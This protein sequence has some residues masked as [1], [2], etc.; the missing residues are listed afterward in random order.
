MDNPD[1][2]PED[3][4]LLEGAAAEPDEA[5]ASERGGEAAKPGDA[6]FSPDVVAAS[7]RPLEAGSILSLAE[8]REVAISKAAA[9]LR[10]GGLVVVPTDTVYGVAANAFD[11]N[12][13]AK[14]FAAKNRPRS[15][16]LPV[17]VSRPRQAW[18]L[19]SFVPPVAAELAAEFWPGALTLV[20]P[21]TEL[22]WDLGDATGTIALRMPANPD[23][24]ELLERVGPVACTSANITGEPTP[25]RIEEIREKLGEQIGIYLDGGPSTL[26]TGSTIVDCS[27]GQIRV[28]REGPISVAQVQ[29]AALR[30]VQPPRRT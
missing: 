5:A 2:N 28:I 24:I 25:A 19:C 12:A 16:P 21:A 14:I 15:L 11:K 8:E 1:L 26:D 7:I 27:A 29:A 23:L 10:A 6:G 22:D 4:E 18:A 20:M 13:T 17:L 3:G 30:A 9:E